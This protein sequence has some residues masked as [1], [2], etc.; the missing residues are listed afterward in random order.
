M[1]LYSPLF[2]TWA[3]LPTP[4]HTPKNFPSVHNLQLEVVYTW[5]E[6]GCSTENGCDHK[7]TQIQNHIHA[8]Y[9]T[10]M[11]ATNK[12]QEFGRYFMGHSVY[13]HVGNILFSIQI[14]KLFKRCAKVNIL[15][16][17]SGN[18]NNRKFEKL[19]NYDLHNLPSIYPSQEGGP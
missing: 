17:N 2:A 7:R 9:F 10:K 18:K 15:H 14:F 6:Q 5:Q 12:G 13:K 16:S 3:T 4:T 19:H 11:K 1:W 8:K